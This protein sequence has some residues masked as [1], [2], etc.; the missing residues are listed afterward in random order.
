MARAEK[1]GAL[2]C[3]RRSPQF[4]LDS[5]L[6][7]PKMILGGLHLPRPEVGSQFPNQGLKVGH[8][9]KAQNPNQLAA[10]GAPLNGSLMSLSFLVFRYPNPTPVSWKFAQVH[11]VALPSMAP[12]K[13]PV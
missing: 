9:A 10:R 2:S 8:G 5:Q 3:G 1:S 11:G 4:T 6:L 13:L 7:V 12:A